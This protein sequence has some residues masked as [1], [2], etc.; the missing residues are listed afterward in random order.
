M[1]VSLLLIDDNPGNLDAFVHWRIFEL[2]LQQQA[3]NGTGQCHKIALCVKLYK[4]LTLGTRMDTHLHDT[5]TLQ[6]LRRRSS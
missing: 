5:I 1:R 3:T 6:A 4:N 2:E